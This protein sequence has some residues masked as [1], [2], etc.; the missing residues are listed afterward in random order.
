MT[1]SLCDS[2]ICIK[3]CIYFWFTG[4]LASD[5]CV[6]NI[7]RVSFALV[8]R[9]SSYR[10]LQLLLL[11]AMKVNIC[12]NSASTRE[13]Y[14]GDKCVGFSIRLNP[15]QGKHS[16]SRSVLVHESVLAAY[17]NFCISFNAKISW[18]YW[19]LVPV[20]LYK[21]Y[22]LIFF[23]IDIGTDPYRTNKLAKYLDPHKKRI[24][25]TV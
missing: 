13:G 24:W 6:H 2:Q 10:L 20:P 12:F 16:V 14:L 22:S 9:A 21:Y 3:I 19:L 7:Q 15:F 18:N 17:V 5:S 25:T 8:S 1:C 4:T 11:A 23:H